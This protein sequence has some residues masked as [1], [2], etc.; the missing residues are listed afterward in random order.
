M[1]SV[2]LPSDT[3]KC[4]STEGLDEDFKY[5]GEHVHELL[6]YMQEPKFSEHL[7][8]F[9]QTVKSV[10]A[11]LKVVGNAAMFLEDCSKHKTSG[12]PSTYCFPIVGS[13]R[14]RSCGSKLQKINHGRF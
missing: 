5:L 3:R 9:P 1:H 13:P 7:S 6:N 12:E 2:G 14:R 4:T 10:Q 11:A 8:S